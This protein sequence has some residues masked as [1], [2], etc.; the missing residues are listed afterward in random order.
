MGPIGPFYHSSHRKVF[1]FHTIFDFLPP[2]IT[3]AIIS[4]RSLGMKKIISQCRT[5]GVEEGDDESFAKLA[6]LATAKLFAGLSGDDQSA[7]M[8]ERDYAL[9]A[10]KKSRAKRARQEEE[11]NRLSSDRRIAF[12]DVLEV[13]GKGKKKSSKRGLS[14]EDAAGFADFIKSASV[15]SSS[16]S[17]KRTSKVDEE[18]EPEEDTPDTRQ[19]SLLKNTNP[20]NLSKQDATKLRAKIAALENKIYQ[21]KRAARKGASARKVSKDRVVPDGHIIKDGVLVKSP[22]HHTHHINTTTKKGGQSNN[23][24]WSDEDSS[25]DE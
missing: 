15:K 12:D 14:E 8:E 24:M 5:S 11:S 2:P 1:H 20:M 16:K 13:S 19:L 9:G 22:Y 3:I 6:R 10:V 18:E 23:E 17:S 25:D 21:D 4:V 7:L